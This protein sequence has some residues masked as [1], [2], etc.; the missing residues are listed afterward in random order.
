MEVYMIM[1]TRAETRNL[2]QGLRA[3]M[4]WTRTHTYLA[5]RVVR[6]KFDEFRPR[7]IAIYKIG[8]LLKAA[9]IIM[10]KMSFGNRHMLSSILCLHLQTSFFGFNED[11]KQL[12]S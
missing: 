11:V 1:E 6:H 10:P 7:L 2:I 9:L 8:Q 4:F 3:G 5:T 12:M